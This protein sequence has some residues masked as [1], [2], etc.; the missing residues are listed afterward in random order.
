MSLTPAITPWLWFSL[1]AGDVVKF[2]ARV[3]DTGEQIW[4]MNY[5][6]VGT[7]DT[8]Q[9]FIAVCCLLYNGEQPS[10]KNINLK[11]GG[12]EKNGGLG[13]SQMLDNGLGPW[14]SRFIFSLNMQFLR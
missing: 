9:Q 4:I 13:R 7:C 10:V 1:I 3:N 2:I 11:V 6:V 14:Q 5:E 8:D 12:N